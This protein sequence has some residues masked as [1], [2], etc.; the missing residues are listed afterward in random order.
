MKMLCLNFQE[1]HIVNEELD[2]FE[3]EGSPG[4]KGDTIH[5]NRSQL[6]L[7]NI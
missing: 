7:V 2:F 3:G 6:F 5:E 4:G 1:N